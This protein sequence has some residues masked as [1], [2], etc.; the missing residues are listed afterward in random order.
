MNL[1]SESK[2]ITCRQ[3]DALRVLLRVRGV[4]QGQ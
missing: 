2:V 1:G 4:K 3:A